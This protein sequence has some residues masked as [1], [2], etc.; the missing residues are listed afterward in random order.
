MRK[1]RQE[2]V[3]E[4]GYLEQVRAYALTD[5]TEGQRRA[6][7]AYFALLNLARYAPVAVRTR[8]AQ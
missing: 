1:L 5:A 2:M 6:S 3:V 7:V 8:L 4:A